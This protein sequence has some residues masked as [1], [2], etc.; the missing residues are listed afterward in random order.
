MNNIKDFSI[1]KDY[2]FK[3]LSDENIKII[4]NKT[5]F[6]DD[7]S[8]IKVSLT[9]ITMTEGEELVDEYMMTYNKN[10]ENDVED[11][12]IIEYA[13]YSYDKLIIRID[14]TNTK[15][16]N[17]YMFSTYDTNGFYFIS[18]LFKGVLNYYE[19]NTDITDDFSNSKVFFDSFDS[20]PLDFALRVIGQK[21]REKTY[22]DIS[23]E[24]PCD[25]QERYYK[26]FLLNEATIKKYIELA[27]EFF[28]EKE[29]R[30]KQ[31]DFFKDLL[32][33]QS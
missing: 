11:F 13:P 12:A 23:F 33:N 4:K 14:Y 17:I 31:T 32:N 20:F 7:E 27:E 1:S 21:I 19:N 25:S 18:D 24:E 30:L 8:K 15:E 3:I 16:N 2:Y 26:R 5:F 9:L 29:K 22:I 10:Q 28:L 6:A